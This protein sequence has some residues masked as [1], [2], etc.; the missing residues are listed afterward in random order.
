MAIKPR[1][2]GIPR[3]TA[4]QA[5][6]S[7]ANDVFASMT[8]NA[9]FATPFPLLATIQTASNLLAADIAAW[10]PVGNRGSHLDL[11]TMRADALAL[12]N[13]LVQELGYVQTTVVA[14]GGDYAAQAANMISSG[15]SVKNAGTPQGVLGQPENF[16]QQFLNRINIFFVG[17]RW[18]KPI[19]L[20]SPGNVK[21]YQILR[22][23]ID[24]INDPGT[25]VI[26]T[27]TR[28]SFIDK[29]VAS[30]RAVPYYYW[31]TASNA[32]GIGS[33]TASVIVAPLP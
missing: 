33:P 3:V 10:G 25:V 14:A 6:V 16:H 28:T 17:L 31:I 4:Y 19:G 20:T 22:G 7:F 13:L 11:M 29:S 21:N 15:F 27:T 8:G 26:A 9:V 1:A 23:L 18:K 5:L 32:A 2:K 12:R 24:D 30:N